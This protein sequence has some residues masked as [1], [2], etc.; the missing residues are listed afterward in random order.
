M[1]LA[2]EVNCHWAPP[3]NDTAGC[4]VEDIV[5]VVPVPLPAK[6][7]AVSSPSQASAVGAHPKK[8]RQLLSSVTISTFAAPGPLFKRR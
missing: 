4:T 7:A 3:N 6:G 2:A 1:A 8:A 5:L